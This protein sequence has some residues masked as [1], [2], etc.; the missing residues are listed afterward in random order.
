MRRRRCCS[1]SPVTNAAS[2]L[3]RNA[4]AASNIVA[5]LHAPQWRVIDEALADLI[6]CD[7]AQL[8]LPDELALLHAR[9]HPARADAV[10]AYAVRAEFERPSPGS[11]RRPRT[12]RRCSGRGRDVAL[13]GGHR[14]DIDDGSRASGGHEMARELLTATED[15]RLVD[16]EHPLPLLV[17]HLE[18]RDHR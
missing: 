14:R 4:I 3:R 10:D 6:R 7:A 13:L 15:A 16:V 12:S 2:A 11:A 8:S 1:A 17:G 5:G 9:G 18:K